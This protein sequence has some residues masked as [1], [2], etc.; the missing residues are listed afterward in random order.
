MTAVF[1]IETETKMTLLR[2]MEMK[3][4]LHFIGKMLAIFCRDLASKPIGVK[5]FHWFIISFLAF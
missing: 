5:Q 3:R 2:L 4:V 1:S